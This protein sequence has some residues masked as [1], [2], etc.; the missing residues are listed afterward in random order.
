LEEISYISTP[1]QRKALKKLNT[2]EE[3][4]AFLQN[5]WQHLDP[6]PGT[7]E[8]EVKDEYYR[9]WAYANEHLAEPRR[10][11]RKPI[12]AESIL[13]MVRR[14]ILIISR[15]LILALEVEA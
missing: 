1:A 12:A 7:P 6:T 4:N 13:F 14:M 11:D 5:F 8:N 15:G 9:R 10:E 3:V 2:V